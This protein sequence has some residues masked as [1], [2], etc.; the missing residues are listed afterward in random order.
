MGRLTEG[1]TV[2]VLEGPVVIDGEAW[3]RV[4]SPADRLEGWVVGRFLAP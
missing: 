1:D 4:F 3:Y 2:E